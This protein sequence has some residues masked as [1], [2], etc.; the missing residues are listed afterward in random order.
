MQG[1]SV[2]IYF[3]AYPRNGDFHNKSNYFTL[4]E[5]WRYLVLGLFQWPNPIIKAQAV[6]IFLPCYSQHVALQLLVCHL[7]VTRYNSLKSGLEEITR[8]Q[9]MMYYELGFFGTCTHKD[10][11]TLHTHP[12]IYIYIKINYIILFIFI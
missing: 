11:H 1:V 5:I 2:N 10:I 4:R 8:T 12:F 6:S 9:N 7:I 3:I